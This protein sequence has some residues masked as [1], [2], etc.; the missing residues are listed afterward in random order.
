MA[1]KRGAGEGSIGKRPNGT[2]YARYTVNGVRRALYAKTRRE[3]SEKLARKLQEIRAGTYVEPSKQSVEAYLTYWL[4]EST[5]P[6]VRPATYT[7][8]EIVVRRHLIP[9]IGERV[10]QDLSPQDIERYK[11]TKLSEGLSARTVSYHLERL[12]AALQQ[13]VKWGFV[14]R[15]VA[16][17]VP[18]PR[19]PRYQAH[20]MT[21][22]QAQALLQALRG[23]RMEALYYLDIGTG[24]RRGELLG[25]RWQDIDME[26]AV[27][28]VRQTVQRVKGHGK[29]IAPPKTERGVRA[30]AIP[31]FVIRALS[32]HRDRQWLERQ[33][34]G[35]RWH[36]MD[37]V[38][39]SEDGT[40]YDPHRLNTHLTQTLKRA[41]LPHFRLHD[42]RHSAASIMEAAGVSLKTI[43][44]ILGH[45]SISITADLY[46]QS[47]DESVRDAADKMDTLFGLTSD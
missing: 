21:V 45:S 31:Q 30:A 4:N 46:V 8:Y 47:Y 43:G 3:V 28:S 9:A 15:N 27:L 7:A 34:T 26:R 42:L 14:Q 29:V 10:L 2:W 25:L 23:D 37:L 36:D 18:R 41:G 5:R 1:R 33:H 6:N 39:P 40:P 24:L 13:A 22:E 11:N 19:A 16:D 12:H 32:A 17:L 44:T 38:F 20:R 35:Q